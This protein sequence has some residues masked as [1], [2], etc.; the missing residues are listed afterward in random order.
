[1]K[2]AVLMS[3]ERRKEQ[4]ARTF[5][6]RNT[7]TVDGKWYLQE[8]GGYSSIVLVSGCLISAG[9]ATSDGERG[10]LAK[11]A[12]FGGSSPSA[13]IVS[14]GKLTTTFFCFG[15]GAGATGVAGAAGG[16]GLTLR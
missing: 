8:S 14:R 2:P 9:S 11:D 13:G 16:I 12:R 5:P 15:A 1:M 6:G 4:K 7:S 10:V 3:H